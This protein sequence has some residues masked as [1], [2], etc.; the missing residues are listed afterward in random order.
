LPHGLEWW[1]RKPHVVWHE[2][3]WYEGKYHGIE[4]QWN[5]ANKLSRGF[6]CYWIRGE[7]V[8]KRKYLQAAKNDPT[9]P[10]FRQQDHSPRRRFPSEIEQLFN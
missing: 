7:K 1:L 8:N 2:L 6:P 4:R 10:P 3:H 5:V 9:L